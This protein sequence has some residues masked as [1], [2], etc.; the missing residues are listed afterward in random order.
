MVYAASQSDAILVMSD[1]IGN[2]KSAKCYFLNNLMVF[3]SIELVSHRQKKLNA[4]GRNS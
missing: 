2:F 1:S 3:N 4:Q